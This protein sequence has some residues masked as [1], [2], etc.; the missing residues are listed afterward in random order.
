M[1]L[2]S[3]PEGS[4]R[5]DGMAPPPLPAKVQQ[6]TDFTAEGSPPPGK[7]GTERPV[8]PESGPDVPKSALGEDGGR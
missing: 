3:T 2:R 7:V 6:E 4:R 1:K 5:H 8:L